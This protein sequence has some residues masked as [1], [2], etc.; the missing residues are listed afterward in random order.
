[1]PRELNLGPPWPVESAGGGVLRPG[2][3]IPTTLNGVKYRSRLEA[4]VAQ[5]L[6]DLGYKFE[7]ETKSFLL[8]GSH[9]APDFFLPEAGQFVEARGYV[10]ETSEPTLD[11]FAELIQPAE[12]FVFY[13]DRAEFVWPGY[14]RT[15]AQAVVC[16]HIHASL[17]T[18][19]GVEIG[20]RCWLCENFG[21]PKQPRIARS[22]LEIVVRS[23]VPALVSEV[24]R[25]YRQIRNGECE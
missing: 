11:A 9:F 6:M 22:A 7:Y 10:T 18:L 4:N 15:P 12:L 3:A 16:D 21:E 23:S 17:I 14:G 13:Q 5:F 25:N 19:C 2:T 20:Q 1:M 8:N 24:S